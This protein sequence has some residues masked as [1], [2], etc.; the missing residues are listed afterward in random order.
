MKYK[1]LVINIFILS[2][3]EGELIKTKNLSKCWALS[4]LCWILNISATQDDKEHYIAQHSVSGYWWIS[5]IL[6]VIGTIVNGFVLYIFIQERKNNLFGVNA[7]IWSVFMLTILRIYTITLF[8]LYRMD[9]FY[10]LAYTLSAHLRNDKMITGSTFLE[11][12]IDDKWVNEWLLLPHTPI[13]QGAV[14]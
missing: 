4:V 5:S 14:F 9:N 2:V 13:K 12:L 1:I 8:F 7:M 11:N 6:N 3:V 10:R